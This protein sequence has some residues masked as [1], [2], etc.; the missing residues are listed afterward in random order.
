MSC[1]GDTFEDID[2]DIEFNG[3]RSLGLSV[4]V[5][6]SPDVVVTDTV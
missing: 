1:G 5:T 6:T 2:V 4:Y 3:K